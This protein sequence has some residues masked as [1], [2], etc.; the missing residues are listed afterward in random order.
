MFVFTGYLDGHYK[1]ENLPAAV[2]VV[3]WSS[4]GRVTVLW[5]SSQAV[6]WK[7]ELIISRGFESLACFVFFVFA[8][9]LGCYSNDIKIFFQGLRRDFG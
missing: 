9:Y 1:Y 3:L 4:A 8:G 5:S 2:E 6:G 7:H